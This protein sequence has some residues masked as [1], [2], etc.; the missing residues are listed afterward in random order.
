MW[1]E[2]FDATRNRRVFTFNLLFFPPYFLLPNEEVSEISKASRMI[3]YFSSLLFFGNLAMSR[4]PDIALQRCHEPV[5]QQRNVERWAI[6]G[7]EGHPRPADMF[8]VAITAFLDPS[9]YR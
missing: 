1:R 9:P 7:A 8:S 2:T 6:V 3:F 5:Q 4:R